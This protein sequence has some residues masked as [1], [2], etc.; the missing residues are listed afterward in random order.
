VFKELLGWLNAT[1]RAEKF[2]MTRIALPSALIPFL[3]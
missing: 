2:G 1:L 3:A